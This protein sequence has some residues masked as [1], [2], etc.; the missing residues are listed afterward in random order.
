[1]KNPNSG[2]KPPMFMK[3]VIKM[4]RSR[5]DFEIDAVM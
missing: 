4:N 1:M 5:G 2:G 3:E